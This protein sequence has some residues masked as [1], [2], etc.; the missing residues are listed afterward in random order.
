MLTAIC[1]LSSGAYCAKRC[2][3]SV[4]S[5]GYR[6]V[7]F[8]AQI[9][10]LSLPVWDD[11]YLRGEG[12]TPRREIRPDHIAHN[13][14]RRCKFIPN[15][16]ASAYTGR[17][18]RRNNGRLATGSRVLSAYRLCASRLSK[19]SERVSSAYLRLALARRRNL[20]LEKHPFYLPSFSLICIMQ[21]VEALR[22]RAA[23]SNRDV[24]EDRTLG[25][26]W[27]TPSHDPMN[28]HYYFPSIVG[29]HC[30]M[31]TQ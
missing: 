24:A 10:N 2:D 13:L 25:W 3:R 31:Y 5:R 8:L 22:R 23:W 20:W 12:L 7:T 17:G 15:E 28:H 14:V 9:D 1:Q 18:C 29:S 4:P 26:N 30:T 16:F 11:S 27:R 21:R 6:S 19:N